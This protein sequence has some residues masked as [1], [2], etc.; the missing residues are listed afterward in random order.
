[1]QAHMW[2]STFVVDGKVYVGDEDG[3]F[4]VLASAK[5]KKV[6]SEVNMGAPVYSTPIVA[7]G[8]LFVGTQTHLLRDRR[9]RQGRSNR[10]QQKAHRPSGARGQCTG[11]RC[12]SRRRSG[13]RQNRAA[14]RRPQRN[15]RRR[16]KPSRPLAR[17]RAQSAVHV[18]SCARRARTRASGTPHRTALFRRSAP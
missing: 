6:L 2:G 5:E 4:V 1:M 8:T 16:Q 11:P 18:L 12:R 7:N 13:R 3:D 14:H 17:R 10:R 9:R 15:L